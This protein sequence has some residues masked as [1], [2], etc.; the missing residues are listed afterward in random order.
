MVRSTHP[1]HVGRYSIEA[2]VFTPAGAANTQ[3]PLSSL[4]ALE[5]GSSGYGVNA[6]GKV[7]DDAC[8]W[9]C[10]RACVR[11]YNIHKSSQ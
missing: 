5:P 1:V 8:V 4:I 10:G 6:G 7:G 2:L 9:A 3:A 11:A